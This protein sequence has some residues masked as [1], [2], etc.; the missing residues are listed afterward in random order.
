MTALRPA[1]RGPARECRSCSAHG[2]NFDTRSPKRHR[3]LR[4]IVLDE[5]ED[6]DPAALVY[7][8]GVLALLFAVAGF[9]F[10]TRARYGV[11]AIAASVLALL[12]F[13]TLVVLSAG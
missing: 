12:M 9:A 11:P 3:P 4:G 6:G 13:W 2:S 10:N 5:P 1:E 8:L 7:G